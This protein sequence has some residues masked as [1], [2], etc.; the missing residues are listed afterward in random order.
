[1][2][3]T[4]AGYSLM[5]I[6]ELAAFLGVSDTVARDMVDRGDIPSVP[7]GGRKK[8]DPMDAAVHVLA[9]R[10]GLTATAYWERHG[11]ATAD[12]VRRYVARIR[13]IMAGAAA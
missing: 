2:R 11:E 12:H 4:L 13:K 6:P 3:E 1:M 7:V 8:V 9:G 10:E 5:G